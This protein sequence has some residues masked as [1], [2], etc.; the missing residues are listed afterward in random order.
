VVQLAQQ[1]LQQLLIAQVAGL[2][3]LSLQTSTWQWAAE[4]LSTGAWTSCFTG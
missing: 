4:F 1:A 3:W 2:T